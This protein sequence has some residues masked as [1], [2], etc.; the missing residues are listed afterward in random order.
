MYNIAR[1]FQFETDKSV[2]DFTKLEKKVIL[3]FTDYT[4]HLQKNIHVYITIFFWGPLLN[5]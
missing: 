4:Q 2:I 3:N 1:N 5:L